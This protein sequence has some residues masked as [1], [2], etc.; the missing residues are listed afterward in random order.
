MKLPARLLFGCLAVHQRAPKSAYGTHIEKAPRSPNCAPVGTHTGCC[1][2]LVV[3]AACQ[4]AAHFLPSLSLANCASWPPVAGWS[5][6]CRLAAAGRPLTRLQPIEVGQQTA[7]PLFSGRRICLGLASSKLAADGPSCE[8]EARG[9]NS[10]L[11]QQVPKR[12]TPIA[13]RISRRLHPP[14]STWPSA[15]HPFACAKC[16]R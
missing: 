5:A 13:L 8:F 7:P 2:W 15:Q 4:A 6:H 11:G 16:S 12:S 14:H 9:S 10:Q 3:I 1:Y